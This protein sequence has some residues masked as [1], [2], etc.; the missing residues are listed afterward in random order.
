[1]EGM[2]AVY[3]A[4][5]AGARPG[6][7]AWVHASAESAYNRLMHRRFQF[8]LGQVMLAMTIL[9]AAVASISAAVREPRPQEI[10]LLLN[11]AFWSLLGTVAVF[12]DD[13]TNATAILLAVLA[14]IVLGFFVF[15]C[16]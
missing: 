7:R 1:M 9:S 15:H 3:R 12:A 16:Y 10:P 6:G 8:S 11:T 5:L 14:M 4:G 2:G 13:K